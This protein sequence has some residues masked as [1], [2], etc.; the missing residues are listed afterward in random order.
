VLVTAR[1]K[2]CVCTR[3]CRHSFQ[4]QSVSLFEGTTGNERRGD[5]RA[6]LSL[7][8][9]QHETHRFSGFAPEK[10]EFNEFLFLSVNVSK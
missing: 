6:G 10:L 5:L 3:W 7:A 9:E 2:R 1:S 4:A 8:L